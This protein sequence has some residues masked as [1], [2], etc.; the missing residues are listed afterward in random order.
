M[1]RSFLLSSSAGPME[2]RQWGRFEEVASNGNLKLKTAEY[3]FARFVGR[4]RALLHLE[5]LLG[6]GCGGG[7]CILLTGYRGSGKTSLINRAIYECGLLG[8]YDIGSAGDNPFQ[9]LYDEWEN[10]NDTTELCK[11][12][13]RKSKSDRA[14]DDLPTLTIEVHINV[15]SPITVDA[16]IRRMVR[17][18]YWSLVTSGVAGLAPT[19]MESA[20]LA[21]IRTMGRV[22]HEF[23][24]S[25]KEIQIATADATLNKEGLAV[26]VGASAQTELQI[27]RKMAVHLGISSKEECEEVLLRLFEEL[28]GAEM[29]RKESLWQRIGHMAD[30]AR[31]LWDDFGTLIMGEDGVRVNVVVVFDELDKLADS[32]KREDPKTPDNGRD[33]KNGDEVI[34]NA[35]QLAEALKP[36]VC[37]GKATF[38][39]AAGA[40]LAK[41]WRNQRGNP[42]ALLPSVFSDQIHIGLLTSDE[43]REILKANVAPADW[44]TSIETERLVYGLLYRSSGVLKEF[45]MELRDCTAR[46]QCLGRHLPLEKLREFTALDKEFASQA[47]AAYAVECALHKS[48]H[49][50]YPDS[51]AKSWPFVGNESL[52]DDVQALFYRIVH[53]R[54]VEEDRRTVLAREEEP[55]RAWFEDIAEALTAQ[56]DKAKKLPKEGNPNKVLNAIREYSKQKWESAGPMAPAQ[57]VVPNTNHANGQS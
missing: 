51:L 48:L 43:A 45:L 25:I 49:P 8:R 39:F 31:E 27:A 28:H 34:R 18:F 47:D 9:A 5:H 20:R 30:W 29:G 2:A 32:S 41:Q 15:A 3:P 56:H 22:D 19:L 10:G 36:I 1:N 13:K 23:Q 35:Q 44:D 26:K 21:C 37:T 17:S 6:V 11:K 14:T 55:V 52:F 40:E 16:L 4:K 42:D 38:I 54:S 57:P 53:G 50:G 33:L 46:S 24:E 12:K 7:G